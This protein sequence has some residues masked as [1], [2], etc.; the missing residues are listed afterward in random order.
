MSKKN[1]QNVWIMPEN[2][3]NEFWYNE[4]DYDKLIKEAMKKPI[5]LIPNKRVKLVKPKPIEFT[6]LEEEVELD[7]DDPGYVKQERKKRFW[8]RDLRSFFMK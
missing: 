7:I 6:I 8:N 4:I 5:V 3:V 1:A 2:Q